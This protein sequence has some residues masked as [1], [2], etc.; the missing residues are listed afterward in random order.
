MSLL[1]ILLICLLL[2]LTLFTDVLA[3]A[4]LWVLLVRITIY[5]MYVIH[6]AGSAIMERVW[7]S[8][9]R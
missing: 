2:P 3:A 5:S 6:L 7:N 9:R 4:V 8:S 1:D